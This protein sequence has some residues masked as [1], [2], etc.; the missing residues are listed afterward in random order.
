MTSN[1]TT[2][3]FLIK[4]KQV[5]LAMKKRGFGKGRWNGVGGKIEPGESVEGAA[6]REAQEEIGITP[7]DLEEVALLNFVFP[8]WT[9][10]CTVFIAK[11]WQGTPKETEEMAPRWFPQSNLPFQEMWSDDPLWLPQVLEGQKLDA[12]ILFDDDE[13]MTGVTVTLRD[14]S[15]KA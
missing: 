15:P 14:F 7:T 1:R 5:L 10:E 8:T 12:E 11:S 6:I 13:K 2:L 3:V 4:E 9:Q